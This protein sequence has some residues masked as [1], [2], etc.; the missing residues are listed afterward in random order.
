[1]KINFVKRILSKKICVVTGGRT[2]IGRAITDE[3]LEQGACVIVLGRDLGNLRKSF[4]NKSY[5]SKPLFLYKSDIRDY[6]ELKQTIG[7]IVKKFRR[8][9]VLLNNASINF[10]IQAEKLLPNMIDLSIDTNLKGHLYL[11]VLVGNHMIKQRGRKKIIN[12]TAY[13]GGKAY[14]GFSHF[15]ACKAGLDALTRTLAIEWSEY[16]ILVNS[17]CPGPVLT[18]NFVHAYT[19]LLRIKGNNK[20]SNLIEME[21]KIPLGS[22]IPL[23]D[24]TNVALFLASDLSN[25]ITGQIITVDG[26]VGITNEYFLDNLKC[27][28]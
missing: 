2:G 24:I 22:F 5:M 18:K 19:R 23:S 27:I 8:I 15:H 26:G 16:G 3:F 4:N 25:N 7:E 10:M 11:S 28:S 13:S 14:P 9:D 6:Q 12:I 17:I 1:M 21:K 20:R